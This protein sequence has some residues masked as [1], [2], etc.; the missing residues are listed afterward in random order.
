MQVCY[1]ALCRTRPYIVLSVGH[2]QVVLAVNGQVPDVFWMLLK[3]V[4]CDLDLS[5]MCRVAKHTDWLA[6][7]HSQSHCDQVHRQL[8]RSKLYNN[9]LFVVMF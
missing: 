9:I 3:D 6:V 4:G 1:I 5:A 2:G 7:L 8:R